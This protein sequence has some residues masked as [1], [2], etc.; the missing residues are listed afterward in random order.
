MINNN[1][2]NLLKFKLASITQMTKQAILFQR[3]RFTLLPELI[4]I[5]NPF[6]RS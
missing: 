2:E 1:Y 6:C 5:I 4:N 3:C